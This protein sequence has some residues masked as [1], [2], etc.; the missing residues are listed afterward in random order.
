VNTLQTIHDPLSIETI[1]NII[2]S[3]FDD[4]EAHD[5]WGELSFFYN[6]NQLR[7]RGA[8]FATLKQKDGEND[9]AS[10]LNR[11][12]TFRLNFGLPTPLFIDMFGPKPKRPAK[13]ESIEGAWDFT[14][15]DTIMPHPV[16]GWMGWVCVL[17]PTEHIFKTCLPLMR[18]AYSKAQ[19][20][21]NDRLKKEQR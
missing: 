14:T 11:P 5:T 3:E 2:K 20:T 7:K 8:Y 15:F 19:K 13:G 12:G 10:N 16:Y 9:K 6:P 18:V 4:I 17:N 1:V 21:F